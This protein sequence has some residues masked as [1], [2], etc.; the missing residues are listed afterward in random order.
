[1]KPH[2][3]MLA[4][5]ALLAACHPKPEENIQ[6]RA[7]NE[8]QHLEQRYNEIEAQ[9]QSDMNDAIAPIDNETAAFLNQA[10]G[11]VVQPIGN[12]R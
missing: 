6:V 8:S 11:N 1:M 7:E 5:L 9:A 3:T 2:F 10:N 12:G 4:A